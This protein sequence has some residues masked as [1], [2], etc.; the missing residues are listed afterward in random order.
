M[1]GEGLGLEGQA[2]GRGA[3][4]MRPT[5]MD[6]S[7]I[8]WSGVE[9]RRKRALGRK[10]GAGFVAGYAWYRKVYRTNTRGVACHVPD[11][12]SGPTRPA[13]CTGFAAHVPRWRCESMQCMF[14]AGA[15]RCRPRR[16]GRN[17]AG[18]LAMVPVVVAV[19]AVPAHMRLKVC[20]LAPYSAFVIR[21]VCT[22]PA[23]TASN[24][25]VRSARRCR[26]PDS[27]PACPPPPLPLP[28]RA[29]HHV[30]V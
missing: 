30:G 2:E 1:G 26:C 10:L 14:T 9:G 3:G 8:L 7:G 20:V 19:V 24:T 27:L 16:V 29:R 6:Q 18:R 21:C 5:Q 11:P 15:A 17:T 4:G 12:D 23:F 28:D 22:R 25:R 13:G